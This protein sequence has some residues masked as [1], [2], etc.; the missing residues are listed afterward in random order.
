[1][2]FAESVVNTVLYVLQYHKCIQ[3]SVQILYNREKKKK[4]LGK[5]VAEQ[6]QYKTRMVMFEFRPCSQNIR[7]GENTSCHGTSLVTLVQTF[8]ASQSRA[9]KLV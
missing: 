4:N 5:I 9:A 2:I 8:R 6:F 7:R 3:K 1:M